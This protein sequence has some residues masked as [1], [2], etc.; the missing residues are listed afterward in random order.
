MVSGRLCTFDRTAGRATR[1]EWIYCQEYLNYFEHR[2]RGEVR[3]F[4]FYNNKQTKRKKTEDADLPPK[5]VF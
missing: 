2:E 4:G 5:E 1:P 3:I